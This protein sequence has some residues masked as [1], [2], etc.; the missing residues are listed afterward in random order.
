MPGDLVSIPSHMFQAESSP[1]AEALQGIAEE[2]LGTVP[3]VRLRMK[4]WQKLVSGAIEERF[5]AEH[6][7]T[8]ASLSPDEIGTTV[9]SCIHEQLHSKLTRAKM[10]IAFINLLTM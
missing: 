2:E 8:L 6:E 3:L 1:L 7:S 4:A 5:C 10:N 9:Y